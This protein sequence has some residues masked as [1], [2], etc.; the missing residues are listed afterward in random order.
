MITNCLFERH[1]FG[2]LTTTSA[3]AIKYW[4]DCTS[5]WARTVHTDGRLLVCSPL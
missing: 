3:T 5:A 1:Y 2:L 4:Q